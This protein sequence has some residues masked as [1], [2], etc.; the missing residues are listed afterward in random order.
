M[1]SFNLS[2]YLSKKIFRLSNPQHQYKFFKVQAN[3]VNHLQFHLPLLII[4]KKDFFV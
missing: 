1:L 3:K 4:L 2:I